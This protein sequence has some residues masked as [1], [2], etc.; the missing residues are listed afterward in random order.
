MAG[1]VL[2]NRTTRRNARTPRW[3]KRGSGWHHRDPR[4]TQDGSKKTSTG[5]QE[6]PTRAEARAV[7]I[8]ALTARALLSPRAP[9]GPQEGPSEGLRV[10]P[11]KARWAP[12]WIQES[13]QSAQRGPWRAEVRAVKT[14]ALSARALLSPRAPEGTQEDPKRGPGWL[15]SDPRGPQERSKRATTLAGAP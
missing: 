8:G 13:S 5:L 10:A 1:G 2:T 7:K 9:G 12:R 14:G 15:Q 4:G 6:G 11:G 3:P